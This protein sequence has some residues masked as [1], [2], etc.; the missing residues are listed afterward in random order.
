MCCIFD[1]F[2]FKLII[3]NKNLLTI[4]AANVNESCFFH[5]QCEIRV[6][7]TECRD[8]RCICL[9][10]KIPMMKPDGVITCVGKRGE[11][12][13]MLEKQ[14]TILMKFLSYRHAFISIIVQREKY[15][16]NEACIYFSHANSIL[17]E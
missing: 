14:N 11:R 6:L 3:N 1:I 13:R 17:L 10:E 2:Y 12:N 4:L 9:F 5:E 16:I 8:G 7:Q 15:R